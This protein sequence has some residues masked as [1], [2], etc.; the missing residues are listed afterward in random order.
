LNRK[1][2][3]IG[4]L[5][6]MADIGNG[7]FAQGAET[8]LPLFMVPGNIFFAGTVATSPMPPVTLPLF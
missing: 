4:H 6:I 5:A 3:L 1:F 2:V 8:G 7:F